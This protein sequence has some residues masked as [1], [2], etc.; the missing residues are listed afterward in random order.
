MK[1]QKHRE[2]GF[3]DFFKEVVHLVPLSLSDEVHGEGEPNGIEADV[4]D[5]VQVEAGRKGAPVQLEATV[6]GFKPEPRNALDEIAGG[7]HSH[8][9]RDCEEESHI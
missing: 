9:G 7:S 1:V 5:L 2:V 6:L 3:L 8:Q 4:L